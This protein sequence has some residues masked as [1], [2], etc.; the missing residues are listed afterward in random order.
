MK[1]IN[2]VF[3][4]ILACVSVIF[5]F[6]ADSFK[7]LPGQSDIGPSAFPKAICILLFIC[8]LILL[9]QQIKELKKDGETRI[10]LFNLKWVWGVAIAFSY[11]FFLERAGFLLTSMIAIFLMQR[12]LLNE[13]FRKAWPLMT[14]IAVMVPAALYC[15]FDILLKVPLPAGILESLLI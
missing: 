15:I 4:V 2:I 14:G 12:L 6:Y 7:S 3:S 13:P 11:C 1:R 8:A 5:Y 9:V 10:Q